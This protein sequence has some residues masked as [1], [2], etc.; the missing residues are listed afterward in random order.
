MRSLYGD[1]IKELEGND[2]SSLIHFTIASASHWLIA[3]IIATWLQTN[4]LPIV[5]I[6]WLL[7]GFWTVSAGLAM[8]EASH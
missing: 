4:Y 3:V 7:G 8:H 5:I 2:P 6:G 1:K